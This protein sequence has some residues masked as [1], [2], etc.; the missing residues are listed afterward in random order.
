[1]QPFNSLTAQHIGAG[2]ALPQT[3]P[4]IGKALAPRC[5]LRARDQCLNLSAAHKL[6]APILCLAWRLL[7]AALA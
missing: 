6:H 7:H 1:M 3:F 4:I 5:S 2:I